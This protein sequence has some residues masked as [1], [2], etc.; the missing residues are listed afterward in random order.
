MSAKDGGD[1]D[2]GSCTIQQVQALRAARNAGIIVPTEAI[3]D[4][5]K[6]LEACTMENGQIMY[7]LTTRSRSISP[8]LTAAAISCGHSAG[9]YDSKYVR[10]WF[11]YCR[12]TIYVPSGAGDRR[13]GHDEYTHYYF[14]QAVYVLGEDRWAKLFPEDRPSE[15][16]TWSGWKSKLFPALKAAQGPDG[17]WGA[18]NWTAQGVGPVY[19]TSLYLTILQLDRGT[20]PIY[21]R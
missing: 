15:R 5:V 16:L 21:Q 13:L 11:R 18:T 2:E 20:L 3:K 8:A 12:D 10:T 14:A 1:F 6:Y 19:V 4:A 17:S 7:S 9:E